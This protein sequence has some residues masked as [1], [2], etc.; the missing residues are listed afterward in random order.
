MKLSQFISTMLGLGKLTRAP[1]TLASLVTVISVSIMMFYKIEI[2]IHAYL[3]MLAAGYVSV[4][5]YLKYTNLNPDETKVASNVVLTKVDP[6]EIVIDEFLGQ[7]IAL[8]P[9]TNVVSGNIEECIINAFL[10]LV[11]FRI[12]DIMKPFPINLI[13]QNSKGAFGIIMD[14]IV[15]GAFALASKAAIMIIYMKLMP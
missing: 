9:V 6:Q 14:D 8:Y 10:S 15:A 4:R 1:G 12:F 7:I 13:D 11:L 5:S 2:S 3:I